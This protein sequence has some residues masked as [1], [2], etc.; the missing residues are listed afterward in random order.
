MLGEAAGRAGSACE[1]EKE[2]QRAHI[3]NPFARAFRAIVLV[4]MI[5]PRHAG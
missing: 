5:K 1:G 4:L 3:S 2:P